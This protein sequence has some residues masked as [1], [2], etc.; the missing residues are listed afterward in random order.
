MATTATARTVIKG[1]LRLIRAIDVTEEPEADDTTTGL[2][3]MNQMIHGWQ[4]EGIYIE[5][6][7]VELTDVMPFP[8]GDITHIRYLL[9]S[10]LAPEYGIELTPEVAVKAREA[11][12]TLQASYGIQPES[13]PDLSIT[14]RQSRYGNVYNIRTDGV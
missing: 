9:A 5:Y 2:E 7:D 8:K 6:E 11:K 14:N 10:E 13:R 3:V 1:A 4:D 12:A